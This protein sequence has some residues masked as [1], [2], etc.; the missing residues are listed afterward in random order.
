MNSGLF[1]PCLAMMVLTLIVL[2]R[3]FL[4]RVFALKKKSVK[5]SY[6]KTYESKK[7]N[8]DSLPRE[9]LQASRNFT[10]LFEVPTL[11][12]M[13]CIFGTLFKLVDSTNIILAWLYVL[14]RIIHS[15]VHLTSNHVTQRMIFYALSW[16]VLTSMGIRIFI[17][18][19]F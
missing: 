17:A 13:I 7:T 11:F 15:I 3:M 19:S 16:I 2:V 5:M 1:Y 12:Y 9:M 10:N 18:L 6:F 14:F 4:T 8:D